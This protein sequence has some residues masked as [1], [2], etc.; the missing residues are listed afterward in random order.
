MA[1][2]RPP[3]RTRITGLFSAKIALA[4]AVWLVERERVARSPP[5]PSES[6]FAPTARTIM[7][8]EEAISMAC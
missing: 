6:Q 2:G 7:S 4:R 1:K 3:C 5:S 8:A